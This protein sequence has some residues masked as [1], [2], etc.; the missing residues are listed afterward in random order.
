M[1]ANRPDRVPKASGTPLN[2]AI[3]EAYSIRKGYTPVG[4]GSQGT[5]V[6][7]QGG[8]GQTP[9]PSVANGKKD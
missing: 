6:P 1:A 5:P 4:S 8:T 3:G 9:A 7:P 2:K